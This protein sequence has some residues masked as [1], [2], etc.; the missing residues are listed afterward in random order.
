MVHGSLSPTRPVGALCVGV[1]WPTRIHAVRG[2]LGVGGVQARH[3]VAGGGL[4]TGGGW[5]SETCV[6]LSDP[7]GAGSRPGTCWAE[8]DPTKVACGS[9]GSV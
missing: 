5:A 2:G 3:A 4:V 6:A 8:G 9:L 1:F 7:K